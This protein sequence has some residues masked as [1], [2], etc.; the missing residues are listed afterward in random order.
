MITQRCHLFLTTLFTFGVLLNG[1]A[2]PPTADYELKPTNSYFIKFNPI[3][4]PA[5]GP[6][7]LKTGDRLAIIG[8]SITEQKIYSRIIETY[9][10]VCVPELKITARQFGWS[11]ETAE[12]FLRRMTNDCLRFNPTVA[13]LCY[14]MNDHRYRPFD[15]K[16]GDWYV[17]N[18]SAV[19]SSLQ[20]AGARVVLGSPGCVGKVPGW[21]KSSAYT[22]D[23]LNVN[24][25]VLRDLDITIA[26]NAN[27]RFADIFWT[28][29]KAG[30]EGENRYATTNES[31]MISGKDGVHP[32]LAGHLVMAYSFLRAMG[33]DG[34]LGTLTVDPGAQTATATGGH[35][36]ESFASNTLTIVSTQYPFCAGGEINSDNSLR[37][38]ATLVPFFEELSR[39]RLVVK[40]A[41][42]PQY[43]II[44][45]QT[46]NTYTAAQLASGVNLAAD[47]VEN[48]FCEAFKKM[49][50]AV[51]AKQAY[52]TKQIKQVFH[53][54]EAKA[55]MDKA[56][57]D[58]E[59][60]R[61][62]LAAAI[63]GAMV[64][65]RHSLVI[66]PVQ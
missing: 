36:V 26:N 21:T 20:N 47:F 35:S 49:D 6:L 53:S 56:V 8:D 64:P 52:E 44:W 31:Y 40:N 38:G 60:E 17:A 7:L 43:Q 54:K 45:G 50:D 33:L 34:D 24:L 22:R 37:S 51:A 11:G 4:A 39:F 19:V 9:L 3:K 66:Q 25:C 61:A 29:F 32:G 27:A 59:A 65:V 15:V 58:T 5:P 41:A 1:G 23:E 13:T 12:G 55:D 16:N 28:M 30:Y 2:V 10:T 57:A 63:T 62:P 48:P 42:A 14:G 18:Y 46:T